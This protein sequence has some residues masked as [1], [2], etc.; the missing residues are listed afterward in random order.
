MKDRHKQT[1]NK[2]Y[3]T[4]KKPKQ[5][6]HKPDKD[7]TTTNPSGEAKAQPL[8]QVNPLAR[9][10]REKTRESKSAKN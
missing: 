5:G 3:F 10:P 9:N 7:K 6:C 2:E 4:P 8:R 1:K